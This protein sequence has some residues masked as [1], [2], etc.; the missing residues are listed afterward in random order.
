VWDFTDLDVATV[1]WGHAFSSRG[2]TQRNHQNWK[3]SKTAARTL[4]L[5]ISLL[6]AE[7]S[8]LIDTARAARE[9]RLRAAGAAS[10]VA[11]LVRERQRLDS[12]F[13]EDED[14]E[15]EAVYATGGDT[16][17]DSDVELEMR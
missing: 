17:S 8:T 7:S 10:E 2:S 15:G 13:E 16:E 12:A 1:V 11:G 3:L 9:A 5:A 14:S 4:R 6:E